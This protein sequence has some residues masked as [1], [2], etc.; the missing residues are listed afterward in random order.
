MQ[1]YKVT[2]TNDGHKRV[3]L[4]FIISEHMTNGIAQREVWLEIGAVDYIADLMQLASR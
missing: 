3:A 1:S 2:E 4:L